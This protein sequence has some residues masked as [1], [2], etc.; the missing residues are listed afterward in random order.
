[1]TAQTYEEFRDSYARTYGEK[2][3]QERC[4]PFMRRIAAELRQ[5]ATGATPAD[6]EALNQRADRMDPDLR[7]FREEAHGAAA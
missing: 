7:T 4:P 6:A 5:M 1:M 2:Q 3:A